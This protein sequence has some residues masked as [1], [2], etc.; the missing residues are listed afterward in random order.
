MDDA[1]AIGDGVLHL[2][3]G[4]AHAALERWRELLD[5]D[6]LDLDAE[7]VRVEDLLHARF[8]NSRQLAPLAW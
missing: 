7:P 2:L 5:G 3:E 1:L 6:R 8:T 4:A